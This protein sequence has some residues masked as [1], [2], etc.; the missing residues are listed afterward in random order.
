MLLDQQIPMEKAFSGPQVLLERLG[1]DRL[2][3]AA[4][5]DADPGHFA[6]LMA[7]PPAVHRYHTSMSGRVQAL[8]RALVDRYGGDASRVWTEA[9]DG[10]DL[11]RRLKALPGFGDQKARIFVA[12]LGKQLGVRPEG[13][14]E[15]AGDY[16]A[17]GHRSVADVV[18]EASL[19]R[20]R[21][22]KRAARAAAREGGS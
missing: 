14:E 12:L 18:D 10:A 4:V 7:R 3:P 17:P 21:D 9:A 20:V 22:Y 13:W 19:Q 8:A 5:A 1:T 2:D 16:A 6:A 11:L 15:A